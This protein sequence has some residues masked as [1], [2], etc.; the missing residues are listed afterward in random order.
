M[1]CGKCKYWG[2]QEDQGLEFRQCFAII[3]DKN[4]LTSPDNREEDL[5]EKLDEI[6]EFISKH[7][8]VTADGSGYKA[9]LRSKED[10]SCILFEGL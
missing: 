10:F 5:P 8:A 6:K 2:D 4:D 9:V 1:N 3:H 7:Q